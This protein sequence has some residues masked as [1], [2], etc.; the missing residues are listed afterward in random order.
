MALTSISNLAT[1]TIKAGWQAFNTLIT[2]LLSTASGKGASCIGLQDSAGNVD[3]TNVETAIAEIYVDHV[4]G[5]T[6]AE[7]FAENSATTT[8]LTWG[9][10]AGSV[11]YDNTI[12]A[13]AAGT[14]GLTDSAT[15]YVS[16]DPTDGTFS[17]N[18]SAFLAGEIPIRQIVCASG[19]QTTSTD[20]R[21]WWAG[22]P[23]PI[24]IVKGGTGAI[25]LTDHGILL[26]SGTGAITALGAATN[27]QLPIGKTGADPVLA[28]ITGTA[29][30]I[31]ITNA[32]NSITLSIPA[33]FLI[34]TVT[35]IPNE[36][37]HLLESGASPT[38]DLIIKPGSELSADRILTLTTGDVARTITLADD[39]SVPANANFIPATTVMLFGQN[40]APTG[41]T[42][43]TDWQNNAMLCYSTGN[44]GKGGGV[45]PQLTHGHTGP[46]HAHTLPLGVRTGATSIL[47]YKNTQTSGTFT[48]THEIAGGGTAVSQ[49]RFISDAAGTGATGGNTTPHFQE[50]IAA[51]KD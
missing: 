33:N 11:R 5:V 8:G 39:L 7:A 30:Q 1:T 34:P 14:V 23:T 43:K 42:K 20:K 47:G 9:Y 22:Y 35:T 28:T 31:T 21:A 51:T 24:T 17:K 45:N 4:A 2:D 27:G 3:A 48:S 19:K 50:V 37:L 40:T 49:N 13:V 44:I 46:S 6:L 41:W 16:I 10:K 15:N 26:G 12:T 32:A 25:T 18:T 29:N 38:H 36:G